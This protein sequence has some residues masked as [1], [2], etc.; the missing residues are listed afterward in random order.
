[1]RLINIHLIAGLRNAAPPSMAY[2]TLNCIRK[3]NRGYHHQSS[4]AGVPPGPAVEFCWAGMW[5][6]CCCG[7][8]SK[9]LSMIASWRYSH[10]EANF[11]HA[12]TDA[13]SSSNVKTPNHGFF[14]FTS[15]VRQRLPLTMSQ[16]C[17]GQYPVERRRLFALVGIIK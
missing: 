8:K 4:Y 1:M 9:V 6:F 3:L 11:S 10:L 14:L 16:L 7:N 2:P 12:V 5:A 15:I 17:A 13:H